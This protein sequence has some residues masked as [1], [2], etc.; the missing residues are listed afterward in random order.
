MDARLANNSKAFTELVRIWETC[1]S[2]LRS[3]ITGV[4]STHW[5][6]IYFDLASE[7]CLKCLNEG[8][9]IDEATQSLLV[10]AW[11][12]LQLSTYIL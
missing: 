4:E 7:K 2:E 6:M 1:P 9:E 5:P 10:T 3:K 8:F 12:A 11:Q